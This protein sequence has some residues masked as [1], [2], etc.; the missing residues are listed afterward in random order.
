MSSTP[1]PP[2]ES[3]RNFGMDLSPSPLPE[4]KHDFGLNLSPSP[5]PEFKHD[6][7]MDLS[8]SPPLERKRGFGI[9]EPLFLP[10]PDDDV[11]EEVPS[12][13]GPLFFPRLE[14]NFEAE[15][16]LS[17]GHRGFGTGALFP[18]A[19]DVSDRLGDGCSLMTYSLVP[20]AEDFGHLAGPEEEPCQTGTRHPE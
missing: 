5:S 12:S 10:D 8:P 20:L 16:P 19:I 1:S 3:K 7:G 2:P 13:P 15:A 14:E 18:H 9:Q 17:P 6:F 11:K 4:F